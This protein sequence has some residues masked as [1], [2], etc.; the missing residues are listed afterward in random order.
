VSK[1]DRYEPAL[2]P[3]YSR[4]AEHYGTAVVPAR[5]RAPRDKPAAEGSVRHIAY[6]VAAALRNRRF[7]GLAELNEA[8][9]QEVDRLNAKPFQ[10]RED[11]REVVYL[12]DERS[13][14]VPLP[15]TRFELADLRKAK[16]GPN[17]HVQVLKNF[18][19]VPHTLIGQT[20]DVRVTS[21]IVEVFDPSGR[22]ASHPRLKGVQGR[23]STVLEHM[24][25]AHRHQLSDWTPARFEQWAA[26]VGQACVEVI[27]KILASRKV[28]E[29][30]YRS[31]LGV[32]SLAKKPGGSARLED[33]CARALDATATPSYTLVKKLWTAWEPSPPAPLA[34]LGDKGFVRG[35]GYYGQEGQA[36]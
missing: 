8:V 35:S 14:L 34:S 20:L 17:Y 10:K 12:R 13:A 30:S 18:Y 9:F 25:P 23:Y 29:Q 22:V 16:A 27:Q 28:V 21:S 1:S 4:C 33:A 24:P 2:N 6:Q 5:V 15:A 36:Q 31:C 3:A 19:S 7:V 11:S 26:S 32:M